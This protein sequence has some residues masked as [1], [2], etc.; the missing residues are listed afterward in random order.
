MKHLG[1]SPPTDPLRDGVPHSSISLAPNILYIW[2]EGVDAEPSFL[3][4]EENA[5]TNPDLGIWSLTTKPLHHGNPQKLQTRDITQRWQPHQWRCR[6]KIQAHISH[7]K[8]PFQVVLDD[9]L[10]KHLTQ[11][12]QG[13]CNY[14]RMQN[15]INHLWLHNSGKEVF[16][17]IQYAPWL[18]EIIITNHSLE[19][20]NAPCFDLFGQFK[21]ENTFLPRVFAF[22]IENFAL[23]VK[24]KKICKRN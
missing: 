12:N 4:K 15:H 8:E 17:L 9:W 24:P 18:E 7:I 3:S 2:L 19:K 10:S 13:F 14:V 23:K 22:K 5:M 20:K 21:S 6:S 16:F 11:I 1:V